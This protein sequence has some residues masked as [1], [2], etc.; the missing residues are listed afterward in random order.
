MKRSRRLKRNR[1]EKKQRRFSQQSKRKGETDYEQQ[2]E[3]VKINRGWTKG[4]FKEGNSWAD[5]CKD[6]D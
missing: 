2:D 1:K 4:I 6:E 5:E 3:E